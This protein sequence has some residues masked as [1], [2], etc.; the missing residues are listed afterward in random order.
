M[1]ATDRRGWC[2]CRRGFGCRSQCVR[3]VGG[4]GVG[5]WGALKSL[6][7]QKAGPEP[8]DLFESA[9]KHRAG[10][11]TAQRT[12]KREKRASEHGEGCA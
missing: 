10:G 3:G 7:Q 8:V 9:V 11:Y 1:A 6:W 4:V 12:R 5:G 2:V